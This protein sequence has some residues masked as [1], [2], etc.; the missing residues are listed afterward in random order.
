MRN[1]YLPAANFIT[2]CKDCKHRPIQDPLLF[3]VDPPFDEYGDE[4]FTCPFLTGDS[5]N[6]KYPEDDDFCQEGEK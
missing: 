6:D 4:D 3:T 5:Y 2:R 1:F